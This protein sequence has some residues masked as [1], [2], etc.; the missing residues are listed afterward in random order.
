[1]LFNKLHKSGYLGY[2]WV[3]LKV[4]IFN[5]FS[6]CFG[7]YAQLN[8]A[9]EICSSKNLTNQIN[10][11]HSGRVRRVDFV[12]KHQPVTRD[13]LSII[14]NFFTRN[15]RIL[16]IT[17]AGVSTESGIPDYRSEGV[18]LFA[19]SSTKPVQ[20]QEFLKYPN[21]RK[22]YWAR[23]FVGWPNFSSVE[24]NNNHIILKKLEDVEKVQRIITQ[25][26]D[27]LHGKAGSTEVIELHG[28]AFKVICLSCDYS[29]D[30]H[31][32]QQVLSDSNQEIVIAPQ[33]IRPDGDIE[34]PQEFVEDFKTPSCPKCGGILK[35]DI[36]FFGDNVPK[37][38]VDEINNEVDKCDAILVLG[39]S[40]STYSG[41]RIIL[42]AKEQDKEIGV[43][44]IGPTRADEQAEFRISAKCSDILLQYVTIS[45]ILNNK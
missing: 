21:V 24:P 42:R 33:S 39:S 8:L 37:N 11:H 30:R 10:N 32:F 45:G 14:D 1:M 7:I 27:N 15:R 44:N 18:G 25:N 19:R 28:T 31:N 22:R 38:R 29:I 35:P 43:I 17:G 20:Y 36:I 16:V 2:Q 3:H 23:N 13:Q 26:V 4:N 9:R 40:L 34:L 41:Y 5:S 6:L 12:P